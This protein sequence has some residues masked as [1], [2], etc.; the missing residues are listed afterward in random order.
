MSINASGEHKISEASLK[1][2]QLFGEIHPCSEQAFALRASPGGQPS[3]A[4]SSVTRDR[5]EKEGSKMRLKSNPKSRDRAT[6]H[7]SSVL[8]EGTLAAAVMAVLVVIAM[9]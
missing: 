5:K 4:A 3:L 9:F 2:E 7:P 8:V 1:S 6:A